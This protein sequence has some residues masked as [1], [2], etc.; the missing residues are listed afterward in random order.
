VNKRVPKDLAASVRNR[1]FKL[2]QERNEPF[3]YV[4]TRYA[5]ERLL[6]RLSRSPFANRFVLKGAALFSIWYGEPH[7]PTRDLDFLAYGDGSEGVLHSIFRDICTIKVEPD[8]LIF[9]LDSIR[10]EEIREPQEYPGWRVR[11]DAYLGKARIPIQVDIAF[12]D[13]VIPEPQIV[14]YPTILPF[15]APRLLSYPKETVV[16]EKLETMVALGI[17]N[18]RMKDFFDVWFL[19]NNFEFDGETLTQA[20]AATFK[21]RRTEIPLE[22]PPALTDE[23]AENRDKAVQWKAFLQRTGLAIKQVKENQ[24]AVPQDLGELIADLREFLLPPLQAAA[25][26]KEFCRV[27]PPRGPWAELEE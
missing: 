13:I 9:G 4:L 8:G 22:V 23:F 27:W 20:F 25:T 7:R 12:G 24:E 26:G 6:Y 15:P 3:E 17:V 14:E 16:A 11:V 10:I 19:A 1:L 21:R 18:S 2:S 5:T